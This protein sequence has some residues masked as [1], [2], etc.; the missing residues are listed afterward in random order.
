MGSTQPGERLDRGALCVAIEVA[1]EAV[2]R[3]RM[4]RMLY[5]ELVAQLYEATLDGW[6]VGGLVPYARAM[7]DQLVRGEER[8]AQPVL[9]PV[10]AAV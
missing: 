2:A 7:A 5:V 6:P 9:R 1:D 3:R 8:R 10:E 4:P